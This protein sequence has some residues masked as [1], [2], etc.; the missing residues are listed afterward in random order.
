M[1]KIYLTSDCHFNH[2]KE[3]I[4]KAR[5][6]NDVH[7]MNAEII[8]RWNE[9][10][11]DEDTIYI[12]GDAMMGKLE[13]SVECLKQLKG[14][15]RII[16]GNHDTNNRI[17]K[18]KEMGIPVACAE[19]LKYNGYT[20]FLCHYP[21]LTGNGDADR[22]IKARVINLYGHT[23]QASTFEDSPILYHVGVDSHDCR[24]VSIDQIIQEIIEFNES[25][26]GN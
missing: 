3:F 23:H 5:G 15:I 7:E 20:F 22:P 1:G 8:K 11:T 16:L 2:D 14:N 26:K 17:E 24:P 18:Y 21:T 25:K 10:V 6:F 4:W 13:D 19:N 9:T 12:L